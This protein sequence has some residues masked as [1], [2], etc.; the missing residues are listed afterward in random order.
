VNLRFLWLALSASIALAP[1]ALADVRLPKILGN[2]MV[3]QSGKP[4][5]IWGW[6]DPNEKV[7]VSI[8]SK[9][10]TTTA[11]EDGKWSA[12]LELAPT[13]KPMEMTVTGKNTLK[14]EDVLVGEVWICSAQSNMERS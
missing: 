5:T 6:S 13:T 10:A 7:S 12:K 2:H 14:V 8:G 4:A 1:C 11:R 3:L 9:S